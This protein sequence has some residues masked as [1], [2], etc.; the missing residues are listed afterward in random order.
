MTQYNIY[1]GTVGT[2]KYQFS[3][4]CKTEQE[5]IQ[6]A[7]NSAQSYYYKNEGKHGIPTYN[8]IMKESEITGVDVEK[9][10]HEHIYDVM[11]YHAI[12]TKLDTISNKDIKW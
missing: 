11:R 1:F 3:K 7:K 2:Y 10:Y 8:M 4:W 12:P 9:L 5:A 6:L